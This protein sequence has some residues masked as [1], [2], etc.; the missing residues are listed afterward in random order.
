MVIFH[1]GLFNRKTRVF[2]LIER[3]SIELVVVG[4]FSA[5][6]ALLSST[7]H[8]LHDSNA[9]LPAYIT[10]RISQQERTE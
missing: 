9:L 8:N 6:F 7:G 10:R 5:T 4:I 3:L 1:L 2:G